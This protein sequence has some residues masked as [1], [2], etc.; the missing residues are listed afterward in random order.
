[1]GYVRRNFL[2][3][4]PK[5][6]SLEAINDYLLEKCRSYDLRIISGQ[7][8]TVGELFQEEK[9]KLLQL[10]KSVYRNYS[11]HSA[12]IDKYLTAKLKRNR[13]SV[14]SGHKNKSVDTELGLDDVR[15]IYKNKLIALHKREFLQGR[16]VIN[17]WHYLEALQ[18]K[19]GALSSSRIPSEIEQSWDPVV[20][21][22][23]ELQ[24]KK[25][26]EFEGARQFISSLLCFKDRSYEDMIAVRELSLEQ[27]TV[28]K[29]TV[30]LIAES[31]GENIISI[32]EATT[33]HIPAITNFSIPEADVDRFDILMEVS[34]G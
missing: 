33:A 26:G 28:S 7:V 24:V 12:V 29:E 16:W 2:T 17:S 34:N 11:L 5:T 15:I 10:L 27:K 6:K 9:I 30:E 31:T 21:K 3:P 1:M 23:Y 22:V 4:V 8:K 13:Y 25:Y 18:R 14:P 19:P 20:K 32:A